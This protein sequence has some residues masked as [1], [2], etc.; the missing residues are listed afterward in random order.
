M[1]KNIFKSKVGEH[2]EKDIDIKEIAKGF[3]MNVCG[4]ATFMGYSKQALYQIF[5]GEQGVFTRR[6]YSA[7]KLLKMQSDKIYDEELRKAKESKERRERD[8][9]RMSDKINALNVVK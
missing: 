2:M 7:L 3:I 4:L 6:L 5:N 1:D 8:I 9:L